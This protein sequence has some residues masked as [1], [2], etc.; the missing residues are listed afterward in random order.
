MDDYDFSHDMTDEQIKLAKAAENWPHQASQRLNPLRRP[1]SRRSPS[2]SGRSAAMKAARRSS[3]PNGKQ[4][5]QALR[6]LEATIRLRRPQGAAAA[7]R[8]ISTT[9]SSQRR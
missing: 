2:I 1:K 8:N 6:G 5:A 3:H 9:A 7:E 4:Y